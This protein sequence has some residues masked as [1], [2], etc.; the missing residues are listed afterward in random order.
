MTHLY[1]NLYLQ[2][3]YDCVLYKHVHLLNEITPLNYNLR[4]KG[5]VLLNKVKILMWYPS[6]CYQYTCILHYA[7]SSACNTV[8]LSDSGIIFNES[9]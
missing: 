2:V 4:V 9:V 3:I 7:V 8:L 1:L 5:R 6:T